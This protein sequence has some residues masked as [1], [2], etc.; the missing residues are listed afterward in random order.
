[1][2]TVTILI[3]TTSI[4]TVVMII[5]AFHHCGQSTKVQITHWGKSLFQLSVPES[6][7]HGGLPPW[8]SEEYLSVGT[9]GRGASNG[10]QE[11]ESVTQKG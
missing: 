6:S 8:V 10:G 7:G 1:M 3:T 11:T 9:Q 5:L 2:T 4:T